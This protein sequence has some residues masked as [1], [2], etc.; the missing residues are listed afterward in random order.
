ME[1]RFW[2]ARA[3]ARPARRWA[4][5]LAIGAALALVPVRG[6]EKAAATNTPNLALP[7]PRHY[8]NL[9]PDNFDHVRTKN[10]E[11]VVLDVRTP[12]EYA[13]GHI[14]GAK[15]IDFKAADFAEQVGKLD[16]SKLYLVHCA[17]GVRS[18][19]ACE[20]MHTAGFTH[21][22]NLE[23]GMKAWEAAGKPVEK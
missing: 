5:A 23:G 2:S 20:I 15:L 16:K 7:G 14:P 19:K 10:T 3:D 8:F 11:S 21:L 4:A 22:I 1:S 17:A 6:E 9:K 13:A 12:S 18:A